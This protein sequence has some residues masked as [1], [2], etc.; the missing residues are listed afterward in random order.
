M[1]KIY[2]INEDTFVIL[3][4]G[5]ALHLSYAEAACYLIEAGAL[6]SEAK[7]MLSDLPSTDKIDTLPV[8]KV[9]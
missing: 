2:C 8:D 5:D 9:A 7:Q 6:P 4:L 3:T 1:I